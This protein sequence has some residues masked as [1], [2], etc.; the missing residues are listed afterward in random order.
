MREMFKGGECKP[1]H[2][3]Q[4]ASYLKD[5]WSFHKGKDNAKDDSKAEA[6][7]APKEEKVLTVHEQAEALG[8]PTHEDGKKIHHKTL[9]KRIAEA[10]DGEQD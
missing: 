8:I 6:K 4:Q 1:V 2:T 10:K 9:A 3:Y 7:E 5:G